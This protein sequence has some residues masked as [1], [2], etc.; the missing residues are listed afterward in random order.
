MA[1]PPQPPIELPSSEEPSGDPLI[2]EALAW[3]VHLHSG[4]EKPEDWAAF[5]DW[6]TASEDHRRAGAAAKQLWEQV[7]PALLQ[8]RKSRNRTIPVVLAAILGLS[9]LAFLGGLFGPP[10]S[11]FADYRSSTGEVRSVTL[12]DGSRVDLDTGTSF[13]VSDGGRTITLYTGQVFVKVS[14][15]PARPFTVLAGTGRVRAIG[16]AFAVRR[17]AGRITVVVSESVVRVNVPRDGP[18]ATADIA[19]GQAISYSSTGLGAPETVD[20]AAATSWRSG[21]LVF[22]GRPLGAVI[23]E[24]DRYRRGKIFILDAAIEQ[25]AVTGNFDVRD[26]DAFL[27]SL[28]L[29]LPVRVHRMPGIAVIRRDPARLLPAR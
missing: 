19:A 14:P 15:D 5:E 28:Q 22:H 29:A 12:R 16:T 25:L 23:A 21:E 17:D 18:T 3:L 10:A 4:E 1:K 13:D 6:Q 2:R 27:E 9:A 11:F 8:G 26:P 7:G 20:V 24:L